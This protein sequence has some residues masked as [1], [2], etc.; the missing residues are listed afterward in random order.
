[1]ARPNA[2]ATTAG[3]VR[4]H[5]RAELRSVNPMTP[6]RAAPATIRIR[7]FASLREAAGWA[8][9]TWPLAPPAAAM[10]APAAAEAAGAAP[11]TPRDLWPQ[12]ALP[13]AL[14]EVRV[15]INQRFASADSPL[16][17]GDELAFLPPISGG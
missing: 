10:E 12:L 1:M 7:L 16:Q 9:R 6:S 4:S 17:P 14:S 15:A 5:R 11:L 8:E 2:A 13:G 3:H